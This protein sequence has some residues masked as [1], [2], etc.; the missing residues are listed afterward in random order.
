MKAFTKL[1]EFVDGE[2]RIKGDPPVV[3]PLRDLVA[4]GDLDD[5]RTW[6]EERIRSYRRTLQPD[7]RT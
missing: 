3:V 5:V 7:R 6:L 2:H 4:E 1:T